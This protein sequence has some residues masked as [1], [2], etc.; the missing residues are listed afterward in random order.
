MAA[1]IPNAF[2][3]Y[4]LTD[5][6]QASGTI[7]TVLQQQVLQN[8]VSQIAEQKLALVF[9]KSDPLEFGIQVAYLDGQIR[10]MQFLLQ[11]SEATQQ[12]VLQ[13]AQ[14]SNFGE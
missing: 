2:C 9:D 4:L 12:L 3:T 6:E 13:R 1:L 7:L 8:R 14:N 11:E 10:I 5:D